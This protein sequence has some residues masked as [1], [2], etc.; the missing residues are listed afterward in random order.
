MDDKTYDTVCAITGELLT[1][2]DR[3]ETMYEEV[4]DALGI[5]PCIYTEQH[6]AILARARACKAAYDVV[7]K[8]V[9]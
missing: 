2:L 7:T 1:K 8:E 5:K 3:A 9:V 6:P 4:A